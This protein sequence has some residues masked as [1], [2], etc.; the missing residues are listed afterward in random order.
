MSAT[1]KQQPKPSLGNKNSDSNRK[2]TGVPSEGGQKKTAPQRAWSGMNPITQRSTTPG[3][4]NGSISQPRPGAQKTAVSQESNSAD[5]QTHDRLLYLLGN[6]M[7]LTA[8]VTVKNGDVFSGIFCGAAMEINE[9]NYLLKMVQKIKSGVKTEAN[10]VPELLNEYT[11]VGEDHAMSFDLK[12]VVD[13]AV[14]GATFDGRDKPQNGFRTDADI[15]GNIALRERN[16]QRWEPSAEAEVDLSL[17]SADRSWDQFR[18]NEQR[19]GLKSDYD[20]HIYTTRIDKSHPNYL[21]REAEA[22]RIAREIEG[23]PTENVHIR[24]ERNIG[25]N[26]ASLNEEE[27]YSGV[28]RKT[29]D[30]PPLQST[31][32]NRYQPPARRA[33]TGKPTVSGAP[34]DPAIISLQMANAATESQEQRTAS[35]EQPEQGTDVV[36]TKAEQG[37][38]ADK[39]T[40]KSS[41]AG[42]D[43]PPTD[44]RPA[45][46]AKPAKAGESATANVEN[47]LLDS[48][49][50]FASNEKMKF[51]DHR[52]QRV[53]QDKAIKLNDLMKFSQ[54]FKLLTPVPKDLVPILAKDKSKQEEIIANAQRNAESS[55]TSPSNA[56]ASA[57]DQKPSKLL[58]EAKY[59]GKDTTSGRQALPLP[60]GQAVRERQ[61][62]HHNIPFTSSSKSGQGLLSHRLAD[63][64]RQHKAGFVSIPQPL[65]IQS[66]SKSGRPAAN[67]SQ[68]PSS[69][70]S[71]S[72]RTPTSAASA[73]FNV[74]ATEF[75]P[76]PAA[77]TFKPTGDPVTAP[78]PRSTPSAR[79]LSRAPTPS[80][81]FG[82][83][84]PKP[85]S[86]RESI[87]DSFNPL[88]RLREKAQQD[89]KEHPENGGVRH[90]YTTPPTWNIPQDGEEFRTYKSMFGQNLPSSGRATPQH[91]SPIHTQLP[92][93]HQLPLHLQH[94]QHGIPHHQT[95]PQA[96]FQVAPQPPHYASGLHQYDDHR[97]HLSASS[98]SV[99]PSPRL[100]H[101]TMAYPSPMPQPAQLAYGQPIPQYF[102]GPNGPQPAQYRQFQ[103]GPQIIPAQGSLTAPM[104]A[105]QSSQGGFVAPPHGMAVPFGPQMPIY[106]PGQP[107]PYNGQSQPP[108]GY[109]S[110]GRGPPVMMH[111]GSHQ[112][113]HSQV[114]A[115]P[116]QYAQP[117]YAQQQP[118]HSKYRDSLIQWRTHSLVMPMRGYSSPQPHY[119]QSPQ[120]QYHYPHQPSRAPSSNYGGQPAQAPHQHMNAQHPPPAVP[121]E[122]GEEMK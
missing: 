71:S 56:T 121:M 50:Q 15:S 120:P 40:A 108:S 91:G 23:D 61:P 14:E 119:N 58:A 47:E 12:D 83:K 46:P 69:Q 116:G 66:V 53:T 70:N 42:K 54:N 38:Q 16:L 28:R 81:F 17:E 6:F 1:G 96:Q 27:K 35:P 117:V 97:M 26:D 68:V 33:P 13:L 92:H 101:S 55:T 63:S 79:P 77:S 44:N 74:K 43:A 37:P 80:A 118:P 111:Q 84:K 106:P 93:Q 57:S 100:Q 110:P 122:G 113:Q 9:S 30:Y 45:A 22:E 67:A 21:Q 19:F 31:Q 5:R 24:E 8:S 114:Y 73:K 107:I 72:V 104:M 65:P 88:K 98:S 3:Q 36:A 2:P 29:Q 41:S 85:L 75:R 99:Y 48:F 34:V 51:H 94:P 52:R 86:E 103:G 7:G 39:E 4:Q 109:P 18:A 95:L 59:E 102:V 90:A 49:R 112:G 20:E 25:T 105:Q 76:N 10:T 82:A 32:P 62:P 89:G 115:N 60:G 64:H 78:S 11:G 87:L